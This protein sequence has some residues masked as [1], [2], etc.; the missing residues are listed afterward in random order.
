MVHLGDAGLTV[1]AVV[2]AEGLRGGAFFTPA[3][4]GCD[5]CRYLGM[6]GSGRG[7]G[8]GRGWLSIFGIPI[9]AGLVVL[10]RGEDVSAG[11]DNAGFVVCPPRASE[12]NIEDGCL[13]LRQGTRL[14]VF[15]GVEEPLGGIAQEEDNDADGWDEV[16]LKTVGRW[17]G[18][19]A[20]HRGQNGAQ[21]RRKT[22]KE[23]KRE[24]LVVGVVKVT[25]RR[26]L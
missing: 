13:A 7:G 1:F 14:E 23:K 16:G 12:E 22:E 3:G 2:R 26:R 20:G 11:W 8:R 18:Q 6:F 17:A 9:V 15:C 10:R 24:R 19:D 4:C 5:R 25:W 21:R